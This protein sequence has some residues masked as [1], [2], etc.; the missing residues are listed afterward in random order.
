MSRDSQEGKDSRPQSNTD[1][2]RRGRKQGE[3]SFSLNDKATHNDQEEVIQI[4]ENKVG[5]VVGKNGWRR[6]DIKERSGV[7]AL[8][9]KDCQARITGKEEQRIKAKTLINR[10]LRVRHGKCSFYHSFI[11]IRSLPVF[12]STYMYLPAYDLPFCLSVCLSVYL[13]VCLPV[14]LLVCLCRA[15][16]PSF[17]TCYMSAFTTIW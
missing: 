17:L 13:S 5:L 3:P 10:I 4:P 2:T 1:N 11:F 12:I 14:C 15:S 6:N 16:L 7:K 9:I 8:I